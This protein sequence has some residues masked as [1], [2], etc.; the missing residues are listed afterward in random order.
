[1][2]P[3]PTIYNILI[4]ATRVRRVKTIYSAY[5]NHHS[6]LLLPHPSLILAQTGQNEEMMIILGCPY[7]T[8]MLNM[9][10]ELD[11]TSIRDRMTGRTTM[12]TN[13]LR[14][15][16]PNL[17]ISLPIFTT[18]GH[19]SKW[20]IDTEIDLRTNQIHDPRQI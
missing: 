3:S 8:K 4:I 5:I 11:I 7:T 20:L 17:H 14:Q 2:Y 1:M 6:K 15:T 10:K 18:G 16:H 19:S 13:M 9:W 12:V